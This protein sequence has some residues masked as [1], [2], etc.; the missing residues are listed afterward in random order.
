M[1]WRQPRARATLARVRRP[2][3]GRLNSGVR[4]V[5]TSSLV[6]GDTHQ[7]G[8]DHGMDEGRELQ[9]WLQPRQQEILALLHPARI[10]FDNPSIP[11]L[12]AIHSGR[13]AFQLQ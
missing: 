10:Q 8:A 12:D 3:T 2:A 9:L 5:L 13:R 6:V 7:P 11:N 1:S 4:P